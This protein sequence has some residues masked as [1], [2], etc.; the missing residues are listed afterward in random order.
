V[1]S[2]QFAAQIQLFKDLRVIQAQPV[3]QQQPRICLQCWMIVGLDDAPQHKGHNQTS[4]F[5]QMEEANRA[6]F[7]GLCKQY[8]RLTPDGKQVILMKVQ[9]KITALVEQHKTKKNGGP[10]EVDL[11][12]AISNTPATSKKSS[13]NGK[14]S[15]E[16]MVG[17]KRSAAEAEPAAMPQVPMINPMMAMPAMAM[18]GMNG[19]DEQQKMM[20]NFPSMFSQFMMGSLNQNAHNGMMNQMGKASGKSKQPAKNGG[21]VPQTG[22]AGGVMN[23]QNEQFQI[24]MMDMVKKL[25]KK[26]DQIFNEVHQGPARPPGDHRSR[27]L[28]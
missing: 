10:H 11:S 17:K 2:P 12:N 22:M 6:S 23:P 15:V 24:K 27:A 14:K 26:C 3:R 8:D 18:N 4:D 28:G 21:G 25:Q 7:L 20:M 13:K 9:P 19:L 16:P 5:A 1:D